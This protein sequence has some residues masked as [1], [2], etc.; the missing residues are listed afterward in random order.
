M[1]YFILILSIIFLFFFCLFLT[2]N[3]QKL[4]NTIKELKYELDTKIIT[5]NDTNLFNTNKIPINEISNELEIDNKKKEDQNNINN[6]PINEISINFEE[7]KERIE[8][9][10]NKLKVD[11]NKE[12]ILDN[13]LK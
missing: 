1:G 13:N 9:N 12:D 4:S 2:I 7:K 6:N 10:D 3:N 11:I 5:T 8:Q